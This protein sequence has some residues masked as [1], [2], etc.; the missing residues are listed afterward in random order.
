MEKFLFLIIRSG[1][2]SAVIFSH[3]DPSESSKSA[4]SGDLGAGSDGGEQQSMSLN[5]KLA[6]ARE[7]VNFA[8]GNVEQVKLLFPPWPTLFEKPPLAPDVQGF[9]TRLLYAIRASSVI[10]LCNRETRKT[11]KDGQSKQSKQN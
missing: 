10:V 9:S 6:V 11:G 8:R 7:L 3:I 5:R 1:L 2:H 4:S